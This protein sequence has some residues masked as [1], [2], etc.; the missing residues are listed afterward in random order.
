M[1][2]YNQKAVP[3]G[4]NTTMENTVKFTSS[5]MHTGSMR[6]HT[7]FTPSGA[8][9]ATDVPTALGGRGENPTPGDMLAACVASCM[10]SMI[11]Y[12]GRRIEQDTE[13]IC[14]KAACT[15]GPRGISGIELDISVPI[16]VP[17]AERKV[18]EAAARS[19]PV[20]NAI[21]PD[22][23]KKITWHWAN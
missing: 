12:T 3:T 20:G 16:T 23:P 21:H 15:E 7:N 14:I 4:G 10:L 17:A 13:G 11:A 1:Q 2:R 18:L 22:I 5:T 6:C 9:F 19:C 8:T